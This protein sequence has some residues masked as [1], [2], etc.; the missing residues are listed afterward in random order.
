MKSLCTSLFR[1]APLRAGWAWWLLWALGVSVATGWLAPTR[2]PVMAQPP[3]GGEVCWPEFG[4]WMNRFAEC[5]PP[6]LSMTLTAPECAQGCAEYTGIWRQV[7]VSMC[8]P[9]TVPPTLAIDTPGG[10]D[11]MPLSPDGCAPGEPC[12]NWR[13]VSQECVGPNRSI[14]SVTV[15]HPGVGIKQVYVNQSCCSLCSA[16]RIRTYKQFDCNEQD[17]GVQL[18][19]PPV[20]VAAPP[21]EPPSCLM[22]ARTDIKITRCEPIPVTTLFYVIVTFIDGSRRTIFLQPRPQCA[23]QPVCNVWIGTTG[24]SLQE[25]LPTFS[26]VEVP[27]ELGIDIRAVLAESWCCECEDFVPNP[28]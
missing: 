28:C 12:R 17:P 19:D 16:L 25:F 23:G 20:V 8:D 2:A 13:T 9:T 5:T 22:G 18:V 15:T 26:K 4:W 10:P 6:V 14:E 24:C 21:C 7:L 1:H 3:Q 11:L 27:P